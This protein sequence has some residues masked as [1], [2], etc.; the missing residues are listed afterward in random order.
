M[1]SG[2]KMEGSHSSS[3]EKKISDFLQISQEYCSLLALQ[4]KNRQI[5]LSTITETRSGSLKITLEY[6]LIVDKISNQKSPDSRHFGNDKHH[7]STS[8][9]RTPVKRKSPSRRK[10]DRE[11]F[12]KFLERKREKK[13]GKTVSRDLP[14]TSIPPPVQP[15]DLATASNAT[16]PNQCPPPPDSSV[17]PVSPSV[18]IDTSHPT[19]ESPPS[20]VSHSLAIG[21][22]DSSD[23]DS[24]DSDSGS[25]TQDSPADM[26][27]VCNCGYCSPT[28]A[29]VINFDPLNMFIQCSYCEGHVSQ[30]PRGLK[31]CSK[32]LSVAYCS[33]VCQSKDWKEGGH[34]ADCCEEKAALIR[35]FRQNSLER[36][37]QAMAILR[38]H[39]CRLIQTLDQ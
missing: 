24:P 2:A 33:R 5:G 28:I 29:E 36:K 27:D 1:T 18:P 12:R 15:S 25:E 8:K 31:Q 19:A 30:F 14:N 7:A 22:S 9:A 38:Q 13:A 32:C 34:K 17:T 6:H 4:L 26:Q 3:E 16:A 10:R 37:E 11:R 20:E 35:Q 21:S 39:N 23:S